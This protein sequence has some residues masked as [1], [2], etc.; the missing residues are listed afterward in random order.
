M[1]KYTVEKTLI[2]VMLCACLALWCENSWRRGPSERVKSG[3]PF[4]V[5]W[6]NRRFCL[7]DLVVYCLL[8]M[9]VNS[10]RACVCKCM[11]VQ[12]VWDVVVWKFATVHWERLCLDN[13]DNWHRL[14]TARTA[15]TGIFLMWPSF[16]MLV[17]LEVKH[18]SLWVR[19]L[20]ISHVHSAS[21]SIHA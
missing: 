9:C 21:S 5:H 16:Y 14:F 7:F 10:W 18:T 13:T 4:E 8:N 11:H 3:T 19:G 1:G 20:G 6:P 12:R 15:N 17:N 2:E